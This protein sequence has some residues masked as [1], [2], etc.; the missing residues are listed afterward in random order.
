MEIEAGDRLFQNLECA[1]FDWLLGP[2]GPIS[3]Q[4]LTT[5]LRLQ[6]WTD[7]VHPPRY[8]SIWTHCL[9]RESYSHWRTCGLHKGDRLCLNV[10]YASGG[11]SMPQ[12]QYRHRRRDFTG[13]KPLAVMPDVVRSSYLLGIVTRNPYQ[14]QG[15]QRSLEGDPSN[16]PPAVRIV[17]EPSYVDWACISDVAPV[18]SRDDWSSHNGRQYDSTSGIRYI[19]ATSEGRS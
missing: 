11:R 10:F 9:K 2:G 3:H 4:S 17:S 5:L 14:L 13:K 18:G 16:N 15:V 6:W 7:T 12:A 8:E 19:L 1:P